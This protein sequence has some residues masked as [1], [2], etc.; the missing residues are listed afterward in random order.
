M[1]GRGRQ[2]EPEA[3]WG[4]ERQSRAGHGKAGLCFKMRDVHAGMARG[5]ADRLPG[6]E[7]A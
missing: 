7:D 1:R 5:N 4:R 2:G 3:R 6:S